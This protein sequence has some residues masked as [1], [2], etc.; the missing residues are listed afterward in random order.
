M[1]FGYM[2]KI[3]WVDLSKGEVKAE[4]LDEA[5]ARK[6]LG[7]KGLGA[8]LLYE[9]MKPDVDPFAPENLLIFMTG[10]LT[11]TTFP[12]ASRSA[13][14][15]RSPLTGTF[16]D[17]YSGGSFGSKFKY[18]GYDAVVIKGKA[19]GPVYLKID[20]GKIEIEDA[21]GLWGLSTTETEER[22]AAGL[23]RSQGEKV[24]VASIGP[25]GEKR[26]RFACIIAE[27]RAFGRGGAGAVMGSKNLKAILV[28]GDERPRMADEKTFKKVEKRCRQQIA[29]HPMTGKKGVFPRVGTMMTVDLTYALSDRGGCHMRSN[30]IRTELLGLPEPIDRYGYEGKAEMVREL[31]LVYSTFDCLGACAFGA[32]GIRPEDYAEAVSAITGWSFSVAELRTAAERAWNLSRLFNSREGFSRKED[33]L[34]ARLFEEASTK[35]TSKGQIVDREAFN[36]MLDG[37]YGLVGWDKNTGIPKENKLSELGI[38]IKS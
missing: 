7:G 15:T 29:E 2:G 28:R 17:T 14:I 19:E 13:V 38:E 32:F 1:P 8:H 21:T 26:V 10:P 18:A 33:T 12:A 30:T 22:L 36:N 37:Y 20:R 27:R 4:D 11:G 9:N 31:Q 3:A 23:Q 25:S 35:G 24:G 6:Y 34:P 16:L 5:L